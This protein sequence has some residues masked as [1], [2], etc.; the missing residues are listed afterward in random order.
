MIQDW[1]L[2]RYG[3]PSTSHVDRARLMLYTSH[4]AGGVVKSLKAP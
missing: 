3:L 4:V 2:A 1:L